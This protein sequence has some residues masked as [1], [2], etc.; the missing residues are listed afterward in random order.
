MQSDR[1]HTQSRDPPVFLLSQ[2]TRPP[3]VSTTGQLA[4]AVR[5]QGPGSRRRGLLGGRWVKT[6]RV[7]VPKV[8]SNSLRVSQ[9]PTHLGARDPRLLCAHSRVPGGRAAGARP[10]PPHTVPL[11]TPRTP[12]LRRRTWLSSRRRC[13]LVTKPTSQSRD[14]SHYLFRTFSSLRQENGRLRNCGNP[15]VSFS[16]P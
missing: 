14:V 1:K 12:C 5:R 11:Q 2:A 13:R 7:K 15:R 3:P 9:P 8:T 10:P 16:K 6:F 4:K